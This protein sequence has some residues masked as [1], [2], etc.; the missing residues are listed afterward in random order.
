[1]TYSY[2][3]KSTLVRVA[4]YRTVWSVGIVRMGM[5]IKRSLVNN[6]KYKGGDVMIHVLKIKDNYLENLLSG[7]KKCEIRINDRDY[8]KDDLLTFIH[9]EN[10]K[11]K[12]VHFKITHIHSGLG[13]EGEYVALSVER[14]YKIDELN[15]INPEK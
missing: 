10:D 14:V 5:Y 9:R 2:P 7:A 12:F 4:H 8:Q 6:R 15:N 3:A 13:M 11:P 1:M